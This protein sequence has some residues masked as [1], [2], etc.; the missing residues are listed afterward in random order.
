VSA[1]PETIFQGTAAIA[2]AG[3]QAGGTADGTV[4]AVAAVPQ[5]ERGR[6]EAQHHLGQ[7][8]Q[9]KLGGDVSAW[10]PSRRIHWLP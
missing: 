8:D 2:P 3:G 5:P 9:S 1:A 6:D 10:P 7:L 4:V